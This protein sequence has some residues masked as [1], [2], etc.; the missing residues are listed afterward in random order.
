MFDN[1]AYKG[2]SSTSILVLQ[3]F[4]VDR[5]YISTLLSRKM[6]KS[7]P[8]AFHFERKIAKAGQISKCV[9]LDLVKKLH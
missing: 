2:L 4:C 3:P 9:P 7:D 5:S 1:V 8:F 6:H